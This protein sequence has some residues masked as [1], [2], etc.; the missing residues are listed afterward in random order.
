MWYPNQH[1]G[2]LSAALRALCVSLATLSVVAACDSVARDPTAPHVTI[3]VAP[4]R[5]IVGAD[6]V[7]LSPFGGTTLNAEA[8]NDAGQVVG[9][10]SLVGTAAT[11]AFLW[12]PGQAL[13]N[14]A[15]WAGGSHPP[16]T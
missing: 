5:L 10:S 15:R 14:S 4:Q 3:P 13:Q 1:P 7:V 8:I 16:W 2:G 9:T 11:H 6:V 12:T